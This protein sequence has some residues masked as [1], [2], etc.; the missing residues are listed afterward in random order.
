MPF[1]RLTGLVAATFTPFHPDGSL[2]LGRI[3]DVV[4]HLVRD[5]VA[6]LY[7]LGSTG[8]GVSLST[9]E[10]MAVTEA[11]VAAARGRL[12]VVVQV[13]HNSLADAR[14]LAAHA[15]HAG[16]DALSAM[17]PQ[18]FKPASVE[19]LVACLAEITEAAPDLP[20]YYYH[21]PVLTGVSVGMVEFLRVGAQRLPTLV[22]IKFSDRTLEE[23]QACILHDGGRFDVLFGVDEM[24]LAGVAMGARGAVGSTYNF[25]A[26][27]FSGILHHALHGDRAR[28]G[29]LQAKANEMI[30]AL[31]AHAGRGGLKAMMEIV[32]VAMGGHRLPLQSAPPEAVAALRQA[33][34]AMGYF[35]WGRTPDA[36]V[37]ANDGVR[38]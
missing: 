30:Q 18:Y 6:A 28:A 8:E 23:M 5:G 1:Q 17:P 27:L 20:F 12:P 33:L 31:F 3:P 2:D 15:Q 4:D 7:V 14:A 22:G 35:E 11:Y 13:G 38:G 36:A 24:L 34:D 10:R 32:G 21:I 19:A 37:A 16:A 29:Q 26:P 9:R 25:A